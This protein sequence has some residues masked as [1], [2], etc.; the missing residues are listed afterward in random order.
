MVAA[1]A[2]VDARATFIRRT[3]VH[4]TAAI[5]TL[6]AF[7]FLLFKI[8]PEAK[9]EAMMGWV[10]S[11][12]NSLLFF[13]GFMLVSYIAQKWASSDTSPAMQYA[14]LGLYVIAQGLFLLP[15]LFIADRYCRKLSILGG[16]EFS[17][18][19]AATLITLIIFGG[20][21]AIVFFTRKDFSFLRTGLGLAGFAALG[22]ILC[23]ALFGFNLGIFFSFAMVAFACGYILYDTSNIL[24]HYRT[25]QHVAAS[26]ALFASVVL[27]FWYVLRIL[28]A[29]TGRD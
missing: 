18:I 3:Y 23:S 2:T 26:L 12:W 7:E 22:L 21:T 13:G 11:G 1:D 24:H 28:I 4:L 15:M 8:V 5:Y 25:D 9:L 27:L 20:L 6:V 16:P 29:L 10:F 14:G 19:T 17:V